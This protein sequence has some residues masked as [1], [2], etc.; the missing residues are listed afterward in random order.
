MTIDNPPDADSTMT[1]AGPADSPYT[2]WG[3]LYCRCGR[4]FYPAEIDGGVRVYRS[5][6]G[7]RL[8]S[9][10]AGTVERLV[11]HAAERAAPSLVGQLSVDRYPALYRR[12]FAEIRVGGTVDE[13]SIVWRT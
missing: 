4:S 13:L 6:C 7:C 12:L 8:R 3:L 11:H 1:T 9:I 2:V 5:L 10:H